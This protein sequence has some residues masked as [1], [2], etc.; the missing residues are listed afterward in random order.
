MIM[1]SKM[2]RNLAIR[3]SRF[4]GLYRRFGDPGG[5]EWAEMLRERGDFH[6]RECQGTAAGSAL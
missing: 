6:A 5:L 4:E 2:L 1:V 3:N